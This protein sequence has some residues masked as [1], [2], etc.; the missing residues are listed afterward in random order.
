MENQNDREHSLFP[1]GE[2]RASVTPVPPS[3]ETPENNDLPP[4]KPTSWL[5]QSIVATLFCCM[6]FGIAAIIFAA[7][8]NSL[9]FNGQYEESQRM[10]R[11]ARMWVIISFALGLLYLLFCILMLVTGNLPEYM[12]R[13][14]E[15]NASGYN[16]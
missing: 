11:K 10:S 15:N 2:G 5:W 6:P 9:Y 8:V 13:L 14:I 3:Q 7:K 12:E 1:Q 4:L 16:F